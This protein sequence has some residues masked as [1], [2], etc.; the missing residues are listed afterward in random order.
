MYGLVNKAIEQ[1]IRT[2]HGDQVWDKIV[3][4]AGVG[5]DSFQSMLPYP[6]EVTF[7]LV[8]AASTQLNCSPRDILEAFGEYWTLYTS[9]EGYGNLMKMMGSNIK[10][11]LMNLNQ[12]HVRIRTAFPEL[13]PPRFEVSNITERSVHL[14]YHT[15]REGLSAFVVGLLKGVG[16][17]FK[18]PIVVKQIQFRN[19]GTDHDVF[20]VT[21]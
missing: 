19:Q 13:Q 3:E 21:F 16:R 11:F 4:A 17:L 10:E 15:H 20:E 6:D 14:H 12:L 18:S 1:L 7:K 5:T 9:K 2:N 8:N